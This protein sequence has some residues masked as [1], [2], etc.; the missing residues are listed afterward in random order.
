MANFLKEKLDSATIE[1]LA[2]FICGDDIEKYP[3]YRSSWYLTKFFSDLGIEAKHDGSSRN[4][5]TMR[6]L[7][8]LNKRD[9]SILEKIILRLVD[10]REYKGDKTK[11]SLARD[12]MDEI[13]FMENLRVEFS[14]RDPFLVPLEN[15][16]E[17][18]LLLRH[19]EKII[20][21]MASAST[22]NQYFHF[23]KGDNIAHD[24]IQNKNKIKDYDIPLWTK[25]SVA[26]VAPLIL[27]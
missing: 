16:S 8:D 15:S 17:S 18:I 26:I 27:S 5:W 9:K 1:V 22:I 2:N 13:L 12:S 24:K 11:L 14:G 4:A 20:T 10:I 3:V 21:D 19:E 25:W 6:V 23:G 7:A